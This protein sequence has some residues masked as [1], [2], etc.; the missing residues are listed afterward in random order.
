VAKYIKTKIMKSTRY[1]FGTI[2]LAIGS[3]IMT[4]AMAA[5]LNTVVTLSGQ[6][7][8]SLGDN[9]AWSDPAFND[10]QWDKIIAPCAWEKQGYVGYD[11]FAWYRKKVVIPNVNKDRTLF[12]QINN[13]D[14]NDEIY[15]N[16]KLI[17]RTGKF[18]PEYE[19][20]Y[21]V[22]RQY[23]IPDDI[24]KWNAENCIAIRVYD[25]GGEGGIV[26]SPVRIAYDEDESDLLIKITEGWKFKLRDK[27]TYKDVDYDDSEWKGIKVPQSWESQG[28]WNYDGYAWYRNTIELETEFNIKH[29][30]LVMGKIDDNDEVYIN[31]KL[32]GN[33][34]SSYGFYEYG[35]Y[36][37]NTY[38]KLRGYEIPKNLLHKGKNVIA[39]RVLDQGGIGGIYEGPVGIMTEDNF[40]ELKHNN[41]YYNEDH[42]G[43]NTI[44]DFLEN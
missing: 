31:G 5:T 2:T 8:F 21:G 15:F 25:D 30:V 19:M 42:N 23:V 33:N 6:W 14:D 38:R 20:G 11:G 17:G 18:P 41:Y 3:L 36:R 43:F 32:I 27:M 28:Y 12:V 34:W 40:N 35:V 24:I 29:A 37:G 10:S 26:S 7:Q 16:G 22:V 44:I 39:V 4:T 1:I 13:I 9:K